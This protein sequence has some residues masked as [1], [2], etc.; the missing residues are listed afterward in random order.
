[1]KYISS[2]IHCYITVLGFTSHLEYIKIFTI[3]CKSFFNRAAIYLWHHLIFLI[4]SLAMLFLPQ[5]LCICYFLWK[6]PHLFTRLAAYLL[7]II[8]VSAQMSFTGRSLP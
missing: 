8:Q 2:C 3:A 4:H 6:T 5:D 1:M 7:P